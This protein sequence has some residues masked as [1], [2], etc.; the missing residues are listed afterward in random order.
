ML[1]LFYNFFYF[2]CQHY[3][4]NIGFDGDSQFDGFCGGDYKI[5]KW[6][7]WLWF[8]IRQI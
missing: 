7:K 4:N 6:N 5:W 3:R 1:F 2:S 8:Q